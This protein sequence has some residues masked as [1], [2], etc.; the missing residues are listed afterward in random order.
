MPPSPDPWSSPDFTTLSDTHHEIAGNSPQDVAI[1]SAGFG[2]CFDYNHRERRSSDPE[3]TV[4]PLPLTPPRLLFSLLA[5]PPLVL[6]LHHL[7]EWLRLP[8]LPRC[9]GPL[10]LAPVAQHRQ[11]FATGTLTQERD[12]LEVL[13]EST[14]RSRV[15]AAS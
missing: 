9:N 13:E 2:V 14:K 11:R 4:Q 6:L 15:H 5:V 8:P 12:A 3:S 10:A 7:R 1:R